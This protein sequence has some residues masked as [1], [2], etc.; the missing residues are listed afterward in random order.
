MAICGR[1]WR[2]SR[3]LSLMRQPICRRLHPS[4]RAGFCI[5]HCWRGLFGATPSAGARCAGLIRLFSKDSSR[6]QPEQSRTPRMTELR[7]SVADTIDAVDAD[8]WDACANPGARAGMAKDEGGARTERPVAPS[9]A[10]E[11]AY[12]PFISHAFLAA[13]EQSNSVGPRTGWQ[14]RHVLART[15]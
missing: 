11:P 14:P 9:A 2:R 5:C 1:A 8:E 6:E 3:N 12:N 10:A 15:A 7:I 13:L 4:S